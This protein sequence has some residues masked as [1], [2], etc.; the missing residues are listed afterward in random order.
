VHGAPEQQGPGRERHAAI[1]RAVALDRRLLALGV[2]TSHP[3]PPADPGAAGATITRVDQLVS[4]VTDVVVGGRR[5]VEDGRS[6]PV[7]PGTLA[8]VLR[9]RRRRLATEVA[10]LP[11]AAQ[12]DR[13]AAAYCTARL[14]VIDR[15]LALVAAL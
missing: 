8:Q 7:P 1:E 6:M 10:A 14:A 5:T 13:A 2:D 4:T 12:A 3:V 11:T 15:L 9:T